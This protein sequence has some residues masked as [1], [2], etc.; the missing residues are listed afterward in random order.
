MFMTLRW[1]RIAFGIIAAAA[2]GLIGL[3]VPASAE[4]T[5]VIAAVTG[6]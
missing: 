5:L 3:A 2:A 4:N 1:I 6:A